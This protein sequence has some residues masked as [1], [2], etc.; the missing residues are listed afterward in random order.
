MRL[1][2]FLLEG[3]KEALAD[4]SAKSNPSLAKE[5]I[6]KYKDLVNKNQ[7]QGDERN[8]DFW[9]KKGFEEFRSFVTVKAAQ[10][11]KT[12]IKKKKVV[13]KSINLIENNTWLIIIPLDKQASCFHG[14]ESN[15]CTTKIKGNYFEEYF[16]N[17]QILLI[18]CLQKLTGKMW[19]IAAH[20]KLNKV[21]LFDKQDKRVS[22]KR[23][24]EETGL[25]PI[26]LKDKAFL[27][28][29]PTIQRAM[30]KQTILIQDYLKLIPT[31][32]DRNNDI[33]KH[34]IKLQNKPSDLL[35]D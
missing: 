13:G 9:R 18:Y 32:S 24:I 16:E 27:E 12:Q 14:K 22:V 3:Y 2:E 21:E 30:D 29:G 25:D 17:G 26:E 35:Q 7:V 31:L 19:A 6:D 8:I 34:I 1:I 11:T 20:K 33:E 23:F 28:H 4:F 10:P 15:W 5:L